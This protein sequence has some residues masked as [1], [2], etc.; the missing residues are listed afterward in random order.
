MPTRG[1]VSVKEVWGVGVARSKAAH[2]VR[3]A[4]NLEVLN[5]CALD[6]FVGRRVGDIGVAY[7]TGRKTFRS[8]WWNLASRLITPTGRG[9]LW[10]SHQAERP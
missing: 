5:G 4:V 8:D 10:S 7:Q 6:H 1:A 9:S 2:D 3:P